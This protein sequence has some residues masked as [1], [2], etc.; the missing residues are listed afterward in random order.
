MLPAPA[1]AAQKE[2]EEEEARGTEKKSREREGT[3]RIYIQEMEEEE[4]SAMRRCDTTIDGV[5]V[6]LGPVQSLDVARAEMLL[7]VSFL[8]RENHYAVLKELVWYTY[9][10]RFFFVVYCV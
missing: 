1:A 8:K 6:L 3:E 10:G 2:Q 7:I 4:E 9:R 5:Q